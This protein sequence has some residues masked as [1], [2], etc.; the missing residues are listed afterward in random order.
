MHADM[1]R[2]LVR[3]L[4][5][6]FPQTILTT[7]SVEIM[8][9]VEPEHILI[10]DRRRP[11]SDYSSNA[12]AV[13]RVIERIGSAQNL[14]LARLWSARR[15]VLVEGKDIKFLKI[16]QNR[17][18]PLSDSP[19]D[20]IPNMS[21]GGWGGW[22][23]AI[24][25]NMLMTNA[26]GDAIQT[27]CIFDRDYHSEEDIDSRYEEAGTKGVSL[28]VWTKKE[29]ENF[30]VEPELICSFIQERV[31]ARTTLPVA[32]EINS[33]ND[34]FAN[35]LEDATFD[36]FSSE[37]LKHDRAGGSTRANRRARCVIRSCREQTG[38]IRDLVSGKQ[39]IS[40]LSDWS[41]TQFGVS[42]SPHALLCHMSPKCIPN[43]LR[44]VVEAIEGR[45]IL[46]RP[47]PT[48]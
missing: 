17:I 14:H 43:E 24:G 48:R 2:R 27:Y 35:E 25:S 46:C 5:G 36:A 7:H 20:T 23:Y 19:I 42:F 37:F 13:Q 47:I 41:N 18:F 15:L 26:V 16:V 4:R 29:I 33:K 31:S 21:I 9:E 32:A 11:E 45:R 22:N 40:C 38:S 3:Y 8:S 1:Q 44:M 34:E 39:L 28:H 30:V 10:V 12:P 6:R